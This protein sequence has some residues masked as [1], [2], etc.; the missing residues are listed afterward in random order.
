MF[1]FNIIQIPVIISAAAK[2]WCK[3]SRSFK[4]IW[5]VIAIKMNEIE[6]INAVIVVELSANLSIFNRELFIRIKAN[7]EMRAKMKERITFS[8]KIKRTRFLYCS[9][10]PDIRFLSPRSTIDNAVDNEKIIAQK[11]TRYIVALLIYPISR[12]CFLSHAAHVVYQQ[13]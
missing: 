8:W 2:N 10:F 4:K 3:L 5:F 13:L 7:R 1:Y 11:V 9:I 12:R 6:E